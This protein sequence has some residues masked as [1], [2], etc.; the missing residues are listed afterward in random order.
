MFDLFITSSLEKVLPRATYTGSRVSEFSA[1]SGEMISFQAVAAGDEGIYSFKTEYDGEA[2]IESFF[3]K[4]V[5]VGLAAHPRACSDP[6]YISHAPGIYPDIL[7]PA[8]R[9]WMYINNIYKSIWIC[10]K[11]EKGLHTVKISFF[12]EQGEKAAAAEAKINTS[13]VCLPAQELKFTQ[14]FHTDCIADYYGYQIFSEELW[15]MTEKYLRT[16]YNN[17]INMILTPVFT[18]PLDTAVGH[19]R[20]TVQLVKIKKDGNNYS[21]D[22]SLLHRFISLCHSIGFKYFEIPHLFAQWGE[23]GAPKIA[24]EVN[25]VER[26]IF[27]WSTAIDS[28]EYDNFLSVFLPALKNQLK[29]EGV[30]EN[31][32]FHISDEPVKEKLENYHKARRT[33]LKYLS[34]CKIIDAVSEQLNGENLFDIPVMSTALLAKNG[35]PQ[36]AERWC[37]YCNADSVGVSNR[38]VAMPSSRNRSIGVQMYKFKIQGFLHW[39]YNF[40]YS[41]FSLLKLNPFL[42]TDAGGAFP[43][44]DTISVY[45]GKEG[46]MPAI[47][48]VVFNEA[49]QDMRA[50][51]KLE[52]YIGFEETVKFIEDILGTVRF[53]KCFNDAQLLILR[54]RVN[55]KLTELARLTE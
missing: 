7:E 49:I 10:L 32:Y 28:P 1:L 47:G 24:A 4:N 54:N 55:S 41:R 44:G 21:F 51:K 45:P 23:D 6:D 2:E 48:L 40:Y 35:M 43:S 53:D 36:A 42:E 5:A 29:K 26:E 3:V 31:T 33:A 22:F 52:S 50:F 39:G 12:N 27:G 20:P 30:F 13:A 25:G 9:D 14:W 15:D 19:S 46:P 17:G 11:A 34:D 38:F 18:P 8:D 37:Y 16:A